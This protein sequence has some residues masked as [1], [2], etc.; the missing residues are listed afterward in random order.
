MVFELSGNL[1]KW[2]DYFKDTQLEL[3]VSRAGRLIALFG[4]HTN[5]SYFPIYSVIK[6]KAPSNLEKRIFKNWCG[7]DWEKII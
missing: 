4:P 5:K 2:V 6:S 7:S 1:D 3:T